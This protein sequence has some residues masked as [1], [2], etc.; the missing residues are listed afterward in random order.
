[1]GPLGRT[2]HRAALYKLAAE[3]FTWDLGRGLPLVL[4]DGGTS[5]IYGPAGIC[6]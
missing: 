2:L 4:Q 1:M 3:A 6:H 5:F